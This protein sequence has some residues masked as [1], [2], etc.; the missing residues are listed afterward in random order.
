M[1]SKIVIRQAGRIA[2]MF[3]WLNVIGEHETIV[4]ANKCVRNVG[5]NCMINE[6][7]DITLIRPN[8]NYKI[9]LNRAICVY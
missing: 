4:T 7:L 2:I 1:Y 6:T 3:H 5:K 8:L 9:N